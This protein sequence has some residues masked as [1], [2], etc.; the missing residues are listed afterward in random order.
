MAEVT[1][2]VRQD[3]DGKVVTDA[4]LDGPSLDSFVSDGGPCSACAAHERC[5]E[6]VCVPRLGT[7]TTH[8]DCRGDS[9]CASDGQCVPYGVPAD[10]TRDE[11]CRRP[12]VPGAVRPALQC[13][14]SG[15]PAGDPTGQ[16]T[17]IYTSLM[18]ADL[19]F[20][21]TAARVDPS[22]VGITFGSVGGVRRGMLRI[23]S[24]RTCEEQLRGGLV[25]SPD[26]TGYG[27]QIAIGDLDG[28]LR[29]SPDGVVTGHPEIV[30]LHRMPS[31]DLGLI[32]FAIQDRPGSTPPYALVRHWVGRRCDQ[33]G[34][35]EVRL[36]ARTINAGPSIV[37]L[38][39]DGRPEVLYERQVFDWRGCALNDPATGTTGN[40]IELGVLSVAVD[41]DHDGVPELVAPD[42][43][44]A[45][46]APTRRWVPEPYWFP[47][48][49]DR[50]V[51]RNGQV[52]VADFGNY[53]LPPG[54][55]G[56]ARVPEIAVVSNEN[57]NYASDSSSQGTVRIQ[58][59]GGRVVYGPVPI[60]GN[61]WPG[62]HGGAPTAADFD[63]DGWPEVGVA[64]GRTY[65]VYDPDCVAGGPPRE[66]PGGRC[67]RPMGITAVPGILWWRPSQDMSS[68]ATGSSVFDFN[69]DGRAEVVYRDECYL[70][71]YEGATGNVL[72][73]APA[74]SG[75]GYEF[76]TIADVDGDFATEIVVPRAGLP[77]C[78]SSDPI[79]PP[80]AR[81]EL[82]RRGGG[83]M[84]LRDTMDRWVPSRAI[85][86]QHAYHI[87]NVEDDGRIPRSS[88]ARRNW[89]VP[90]LNNFRQNTQGM[91]APV[92]LADLTVSL[93]NATDL[94]AA[95]GRVTL[96]ARVCNRGTNPVADGAL[97]RFQ[98]TGGDP[99][100]L[101]EV[102]TSMLL[103][104]GQCTMVECTGEI[105]GSSGRTV[106]VIADPDGTIADCH[107]GN[108]RGIIPIGGCPG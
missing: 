76:P 16:F 83:F 70:R 105:R 4:T 60:Y 47:T 22:I 96:R 89:E 65:A 36:A 67:N 10:R 88:M 52:A 86:N 7:C 44:F 11:M 103:A 100:T 5:Y 38:D 59:A 50:A 63:G 84:V 17:Y 87:T 28:D 18:V 13:E 85:W 29:T 32:A 45:W 27:S 97:I 35:P 3:G 80:E 23:W 92:G 94:C 43:I 78:P 99:R 46:H 1:M 19:N 68:S 106:E 15:P 82:E 102:R 73:S 108:N 30:T 41:I 101:C 66:R 55:D 69:G 33:P 104:P 49:A 40:Y 39:D 9:Y 57:E 21:G 6:G 54:I 12:A 37:D 25:G 90:G 48:D 93:L 77:T 24:G 34:E 56:M 72:Y 95:S 53:P 98:Q 64:G 81:A 107:P 14:W 20:D 8:D 91:L 79:A 61:G 42:G 71:V 62:G 74:P 26:E 58:T 2:D 51:Q 31:G 75:T